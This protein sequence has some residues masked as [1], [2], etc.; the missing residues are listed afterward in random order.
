MNQQE[1]Q[2]ICLENDI[3]LSEEQFEKLSLYHD[4]LKEWNSKVNLISRKDEDNIFEK[5]ILHSLSILKYMKF[6][7]NTRCLDVGTGGGLPGIP[8]GIAL[9]KMDMVLIDSIAKK[10]K[11]AE[12]LSLASGQTNFKS[13]RGRCEKLELDRQYFRSFNYVVSR[14][15]VRLDKLLDWTKRIIKVNARIILLKGGDLREEIKEAQKQH[16]GLIVNEYDLVIKG[17]DWYK[18]DEKKVLICKYKI[19]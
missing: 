14:A 15:V 12:E 10:I 5:H 6:K 2:Q 1:F 13:L 17:C 19:K 3:L 11:I 9:P 8:L 18:N 16:P 7:E 4:G